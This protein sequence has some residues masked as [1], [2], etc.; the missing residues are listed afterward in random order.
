MPRERTSQQ[1]K[2]HVSVENAINQDLTY[3][4]FTLLHMQ[5]GC[6][7]DWCGIIFM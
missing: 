3:Q 4:F 5:I 6:D 2:T 7:C 1:F